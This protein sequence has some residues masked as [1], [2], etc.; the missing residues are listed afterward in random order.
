MI[1]ITRKRVKGWSLSKECEKLGITKESVVF[2]GRGTKFG[3]PFSLKE[4]KLEDSLR[5]FKEY[6]LQ[7]KERFEELRHKNLSCWCS[8]KNFDKGLCHCDIIR[9]FLDTQSDETDKNT[10][11][12]VEYKK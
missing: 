2:C 8:K 3:N 9:R 1:Y 12:H 4:Y 5:L 11:T 7:N 6:F 10:V